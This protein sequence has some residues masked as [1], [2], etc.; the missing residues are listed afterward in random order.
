MCFQST[1]VIVL[2]RLFSLSI[3]L[4]LIVPLASY[5]GQAQVLQYTLDYDFR[6]DVQGQGQI[7][8]P[9]ALT[10]F[11]FQLAP[12]LKIKFDDQKQLSKIDEDTYQVQFQRPTTVVKFQVQ[13]SLKALEGS[14]VES[15]SATSNSDVAPRVYSL[16]PNDQWY[17]VVDGS[18]MTFQLKIAHPYKTL[19]TNG[20]N[21]KLE[22]KMLF[23]QQGVFLV[24]SPFD[25]LDDAVDPRIKYLVSPS[26]Q[27]LIPQWSASLNQ[28]MV[29]F[30]SQFGSYP[31][32]NFVLI[33]NTQPTGFGMP[34]FTLIGS[35][36]LE[37][38]FLT[39]SSIPHELLHNWWGNG[40]FVSTKYGNW[41][42]AMTTFFSDHS[43]QEIV[44]KGLAYRR[45]ALKNYLIARGSSTD[46]PFANFR[47]RF[48][49]I[50]QAVGYSK[51]LLLIQMMKGI[52]GPSKF[53]ECTQSFYRQNLFKQVDFQSLLNTCMDS[54]SL[55]RQMFL[56]SWVKREGF[57]DLKIE[58]DAVEKTK[59]GFQASVRVR[60][61]GGYIFP[62]RIRLQYADGTSKDY[63][64]KILKNET[65]V[66]VE[67]QQEPIS[68]VLDPEYEIV[69]GL[70][71]LETAASAQEVFAR[72]KLFVPVELRQ[73]S[74]FLERRPTLERLGFELLEKD[75]K[76]SPILYLNQDGFQS[77]VFKQSFQ[78]DGWTLRGT[79]LR[80]SRPEGNAQF[81]TNGNAWFVVQTDHLGRLHFWL[82]LKDS[83]AAVVMFQKMNYYG[84]YSWVI[85]DHQRK[86]YQSEWDKTV[87]PWAL[88][89]PKP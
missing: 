43:Y 17:P 77:P 5:S 34:G 27:K 63:L 36:V 55:D 75:D 28:A 51:G 10:K 1:G 49:P 66:E 19:I 21:S 83:F 58:L 81:D 16:S 71:S 45:Q 12:T 24:F 57:P 84:N 54:S 11:E 29:K 41:S 14:S 20:G 33:E 78:L 53:A 8:F 42:E 38:P 39:E 80:P 74:D 64:V 37:L 60:Q 48:D 50:T 31:Y 56:D 87:F 3:L 79:T 59:S 68:I 65:V 67:S 73:R 40:V 26:H 62:L 86:V 15:S 2:S 61:S 82:Q 72:K 13:G 46:L 18:L 23:P 85:F 52:V 22:S 4:M 47:E 44:G 6:Q 25:L 88:K 30:T 76:A 32:E 35:S 69:R 70:G 89:V 9:Q 7:S